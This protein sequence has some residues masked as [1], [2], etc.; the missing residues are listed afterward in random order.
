MVSD[1][2]RRRN[3]WR[4][5]KAQIFRL[6]MPGF[7][8]GLLVT[9]VDAK[10]EKANQPS[11]ELLAALGSDQYPERI[12][13]QERLEKWAAQQGEAG[14]QWLWN[15]AQ[16]EESPEVAIRSYEVM[17]SL[18]IE[19]LRQKRPGYVG[20]T[21]VEDKVKLDDA[22]LYGVRIREVQKDSPADHAGLLVG[23][24]IIE[25]N[26]ESWVSPGA[27]DRFAEKVGKMGVGAE[28]KL[29]LLR[30]GNEKVF[31]FEL[32]PRPWIAGEYGK[33]NFGRFGF[34]FEEADFPRTEKEAEEEVFEAWLEE[35]ADKLNAAS[36][37]G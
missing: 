16:S 3:D 9:V 33:G 22:E 6:A 5:I 34:G 10:P 23:D 37:N 28:V 31:E 36:S 13:A 24:L 19:E 15:Q 32:G 14:Y 30:Q 4:G 11:E 12:R 25:I 29:K 20:I 26:G 17:K 18:V 2:S 7:W 21:M 8:C 35:N 27:Q 1:M